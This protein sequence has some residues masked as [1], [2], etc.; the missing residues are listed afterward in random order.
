M[1][2][3]FNELYDKKNIFRK[4]YMQN[5]INRFTNASLQVEEISGDLADTKQAMNIY[6]QTQALEYAFSLKKDHILNIDNIKQI[7]DILTGGEVTNFRTTQAI[8]VGSNVLRSK[9]AYIYMDLYTLFDNYYNIWNDV[10]P[11]LREAYFH[12]RFLHIHPFEDGNGR[13]ARILLIRNLCVNGQIPC[14][15]TKEVKEEYC[16]YIENNDAEGLAKFFKKISNNE[17]ITILNLYNNLNSKGLIKENNMTK[18][19]QKKYNEILG[20]KEQ[21]IEENYPLRNLEYLIKLFK[22][23]CTLNDNLFKAGLNRIENF[24]DINSGDKATYY[25][26]SRTMIIQINGDSKFFKIIQKLDQ[27]YFEIDGIE[28]LPQEFEYELNN[29]NNN[30]NETLKVKIKVK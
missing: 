4:K 14:I 20:R 7:E 22:H 25:E 29:S 11:F 24:S 15:I 6:Q 30:I 9:A 27:L 3:M 12:I 2:I 16:S 1:L 13:T 28:K 19:Q 17:L 8:V 18:S 5:L 26:E 23:S 10:D 21:L